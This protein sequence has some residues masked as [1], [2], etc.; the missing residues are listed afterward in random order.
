MLVSIPKIDLLKLKSQ[1]F[2]YFNVKS[3]KYYFKI[4]IKII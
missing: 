1:Q 2:I 3:F 4:N